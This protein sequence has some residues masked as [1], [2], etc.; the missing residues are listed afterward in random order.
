MN[1]KVFV[2]TNILI[3]LVCNRE[4]FADEAE[5]L[6]SLAYQEK[7]IIVI[8]ALSYVNT[9]YISKKYGF[10]LSEI[11]N[12]LIH[13]SS[14]TETADCSGDAV[15]WALSCNWKDYED[16]IQYK[17]AQ[18]SKCTSIITRNPKDF[19]GSTLPIYSIEEFYKI[20]F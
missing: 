3:D 6:F 8:S 9:I 12:S 7:I 4:K 15:S 17:S 10:S 5:L 18:A 19:K 13:I 1:M 14:F 16:A 20:Y 11:K 2:D